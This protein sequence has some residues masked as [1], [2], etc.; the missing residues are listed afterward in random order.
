MLHI[1]GAHLAHRYKPSIIH[2]H[3][4]TQLTPVRAAPGTPVSFAR[5]AVKS[6]HRQATILT[7]HNFL[8]A[9]LKEVHFVHALSGVQTPR[10]DFLHLA[11]HLRL[12]PALADAF[13]LEEHICGVENDI[14]VA[15]GGAPLA[16]EAP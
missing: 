12:G 10:M 1:E 6:L 5:A 13:L 16:Q 15:R 3:R 2:F 14:A 9:A 11:S 4:F 8:T 7:P